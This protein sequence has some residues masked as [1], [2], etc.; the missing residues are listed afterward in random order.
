MSLPNIK[1]CPGTLAEGFDTYSPTCLKRVFNRKKVSH[2]LPYDPPDVSE[3]DAE[4]FQQNRKRLSI[5][6]VQE[7]VSLLLEKNTLRLTE[8]GE[9]GTYIL[10]PIPRDLRKVD[11]VPA[12]EHLT[13]QIA[14]Q[15]FDIHTAEN[16]LIFFKNGDPA[17]ITK[18]FDVAGDG[19]KIGK[20]DFAT[21][22]GKTAETAG[23]NFKYEYSYEE[24]AELVQKYIPAAMVELEKLFSLILFNYLICNGDAHLKNYGVIETKQGDYILS[25][26]YDLINTSLHVD[27]T[28]MALDEGLFKDDFT[29][30]SFEAN[31]FYAFDDFYEFGLKIGLVESRMVKILNHFRSH[32]ENVRSLTN[33]S[34]LNEEMKRAYMDSYLNKLKALNYSMEGRI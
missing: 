12:N 11:Q 18:R 16:A 29:T 23:P 7:K 28:A 27:D 17:Y 30:E 21:L 19:K 8:E 3:E 26:A 2:I 13:M 14:R 5:S 32:Q 1:Y 4:K 24:M 31:A 6:G 33:R 10:K 9:Q 25:P 20:E 34:F 22:A 15:V